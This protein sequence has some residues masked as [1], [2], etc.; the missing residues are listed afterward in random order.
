M[1][2]VG[3]FTRVKDEDV[4]TRGFYIIGVI[5]KVDSCF[6]KRPPK[7]L[8]DHPS[9]IIEGLANTIYEQLMRITRLG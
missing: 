1:I 9:I 4:R 5:D 2:L 6:G 3:S 7:V 8:R